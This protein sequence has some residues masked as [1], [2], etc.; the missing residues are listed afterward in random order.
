MKER[1]TCGNCHWRKSD[2]WC[3]KLWAF[4]RID[5]ESACDK[6]VFTGIHNGSDG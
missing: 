1:A 5:D 4:M 2:G 3:P 6:H